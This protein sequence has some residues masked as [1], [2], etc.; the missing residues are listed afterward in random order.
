VDNGN[1]LFFSQENKLN[2]ID[3]RKNSDLLII[4]SKNI[5]NSYEINDMEI[6]EINDV[7]LLT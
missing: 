3:L 5:E 1:L 7:N 2:Y 4:K 6:S